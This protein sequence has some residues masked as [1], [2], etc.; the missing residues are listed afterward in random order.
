[1]FVKVI[2]PIKLQ[3]LLTSNNIN[4]SNDQ[5]TFRPKKKGKETIRKYETV[6]E[7]QA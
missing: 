6:K 2:A 5:V 4:I 3:Q 7:N 1:M